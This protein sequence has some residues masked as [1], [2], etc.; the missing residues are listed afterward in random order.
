M[1][2]KEKEKVKKPNILQRWSKFFREVF[3]ELK[4]VTWPTTKEL[5]SYTATVLAFIFLI[6]VMIG[7]LDFGFSK[8][9]TALGSLDF[10]AANTPAVTASPIP[11]ATDAAATP[12]STAVNATSTP[13]GTN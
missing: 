5:V 11:G 6:A 7:I 2:N 4:K 3:G 12:A 10:G 8:G 1:A 9:F 13:A